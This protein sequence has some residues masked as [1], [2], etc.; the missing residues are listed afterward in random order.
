[1]V[2]RTSNVDNAA[3][4]REMTFRTSERSLKGRTANEFFATLATA[5]VTRK[6]RPAR[7]SRASRNSTAPSIRRNQAEGRRRRGM[8]VRDGET[9]GRL[10]A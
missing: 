1:M 7:I 2:C 10:K 6:V 4:C 5:G 8:L 3:R 9:S